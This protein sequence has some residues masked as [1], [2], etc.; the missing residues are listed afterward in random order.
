MAHDS[1]HCENER[2]LQTTAIKVFPFPTQ[3]KG[4]YYVG[5]VGHDLVPIGCPL[6]CRPPEHP[7]WLQC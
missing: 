5:G 3:R 1:Y 6:A 4:N 2:L 7:D